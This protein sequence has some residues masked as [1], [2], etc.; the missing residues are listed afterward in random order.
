MARIRHDLNTI[1]IS[2][3]LQESLRPVSRCALTAIVAPMGYGKTTAV[4]WFLAREAPPH[5]IR[6]SV[7][8]AHLAI[9]WRSAQ[10]ALPTPGSRSCVTTT[11]LSMPRA[12]GC[13]Q[14]PIKNRKLERRRAGCTGGH[15]R[16]RSYRR[17]HRC[18]TRRHERLCE[19]SKIWLMLCRRNAGCYSDR[20]CCN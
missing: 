10:E 20:V 16:R 14:P 6:I 17:N 18:N 8:S 7:Y 19:P 2:G 3:R 1:Y 15:G 11:A 9:L 12:Q 13:W 4:N 5:C